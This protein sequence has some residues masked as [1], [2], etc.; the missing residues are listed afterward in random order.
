MKLFIYWDLEYLPDSLM[1]DDNGRVIEDD[2][3][4]VEDEAERLRLEEKAEKIKWMRENS[5]L[6]GEE[7]EDE[8]IDSQ[9]L[10]LENSQY[11]RLGKSTLKKIQ[12]S[13]SFMEASSSNSCSQFTKITNSVTWEK[14]I[15][16]SKDVN[17]QGANTSGSNLTSKSLFASPDDPLL[18]V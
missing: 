5:Q 6:L 13:C 7:E 14:S 4:E 12:S 10:F 9:K 11:F 3:M 15:T 18:K 1:L 8:E 2:K 16:S 17:S